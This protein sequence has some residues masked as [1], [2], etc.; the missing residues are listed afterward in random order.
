MSR[1]RTN[2]L[3]VVPRPVLLPVLWERP[4]E[5]NGTHRFDRKHYY[6]G[7]TRS[8][9]RCENYFRATDLESLK[10]HRS[11]KCCSRRY[12]FNSDVNREERVSGLTDTV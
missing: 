6:I 11:Q 7:P 8:E 10:K 3:V 4:T 1:E 9:E 5:R 2:G 12:D